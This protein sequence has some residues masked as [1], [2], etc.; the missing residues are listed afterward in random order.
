MFL[1]LELDLNQN[2]TDWIGIDL[3][4]V[5]A[6]QITGLLPVMS[7][8]AGKEIQFNDISEW[9]FRIGSKGLGQ[10]IGEAQ[11]HSDYV[12]SMPVIP[13]A[14][15]ATSQLYRYFR[16]AIV[17]ARP[18]ASLI[19][20]RE[21]L[22]KNAFQFDRFIHRANGKKQNIPVD[23]VALIDDYAFNLEQFLCDSEGKA[24][25]YSQPWNR[26]CHDDLKD[27]FENRVCVCENWNDVLR[28]FKINNRASYL[29]K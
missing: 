29:P 23:L 20:T 11:E 15:A 3:D 1:R 6:D 17:T 2:R 18:I 7:E 9:D 14:L 16:I 10:I 4:G 26:A 27:R 12:L 5:L 19:W 13:D 8:I 24:V 28:F 22:E 25:V 21:W